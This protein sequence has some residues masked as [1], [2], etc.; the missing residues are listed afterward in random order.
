[1]NPVTN[2]CEAVLGDDREAKSV[3]RHIPE[4]ATCS[5]TLLDMVFSYS[6]PVNLKQGEILIEE[7]LFDQ[8]VY[9]IIK[10]DL[11]V[12]ISGKNLGSTAGPIVGERCILGEPR[13]ANLVAGKDG[14][15]ALGV[16]MT[17]LD[18]L[19]R[20]VNDYRK[21]AKND[22][23][24]DRFSEE[25][26][27][28]SLELLVIVLMEVVGRIINMHRTGERSFDALKKSRPALNIQLQSLYSFSDN[29]CLE[30]ADAEF[31]ENLSDK[32]RKKNISV[33]SFKDFVDI[34][35]FELLQKNMSS[36]GFEKFSQQKWNETLTIDKN[37]NATIWDAYN[38]LKNDFGLSNA[39]L[40]DV[41]FSIFEVASKYTAAANNS[42]SA[43]LAISDCE[44]EKQK[45]IDEAS[46]EERAVAPEKQELIMRHLFIPVEEKLKSAQLS[47]V[48]K[49]SKKM[50]QSD[51][52]AMFD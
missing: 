45:V 19:N 52:D 23:E 49:D 38:W 30:Q 20:T 29:S 27:A 47:E 15:L 42:I 43:I 10:G 50:S 48:K 39:E 7:G 34:V 14:L 17:I 26:M 12:M 21:I 9:F 1:M 3:L 25:K 11:D 33:Y 2:Y 31:K 22:K 46:I 35:Y 40:I 41:T 16:E 8:W 51:I 36:L 4:F 18:E 32:R 44:D 28:V 13:G 37:Y 24:L 6:K 5:D